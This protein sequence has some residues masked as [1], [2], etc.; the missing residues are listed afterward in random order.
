MDQQLG[1]LIAGIRAR[2]R[3][4]DAL[5]V[6]AADHGEALG[7]HGV[8]FAHGAG[9]T[10]D[11]VRVP[12]MIRRP[13]QR[14]ARRDDVVTLLDVF[15]TVLAQL[16]VESGAES[17]AGRDLFSRDAEATASVPYLSTLGAL[18]QAQFGLVEDGF[19]F[20]AV[21]REGIFDGR[22]YA[23]GHED[24]ELSAAAPQVAAAM[25]ERL[26]RLR[27]QLQP[28]AKP[29]NPELSAADRERLRALGYLEPGN[30]SP[31]RP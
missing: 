17:A 29:A 13:G 31:P 16:G 3:W 30:D 19:K 10:D 9:L 1:R 28:A 18:P 23:L 25:R 26:G 2:G 12:L 15:P 4:Q 27:A 14:P 24:A 22:L 5:V 6:F 21:E 11:Q 8:W 7:D 20:I